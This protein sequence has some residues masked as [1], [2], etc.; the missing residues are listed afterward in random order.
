MAAADVAFFP[1][2]HHSPACAWALSQALA[3][4][5]PRQVLVEAPCDFLPLVV[6]LTDPETKPPIALLS[7]PADKAAPEDQFTAVYPFCAHSPEFVAL[8][9]ARGNDARIELIDLPARH[10]MMRR[11][12]PE[13]HGAPAPLIAEWR[14][15]HNAYVTELCARRGVRDALA[16]WDALFESQAGTADWRGF[17][18]AVGLYCG[19]MRA[20]TPAADMAA[21]GTQ[22]R[23]AHMAA[24]LARARA[25]PGPVA[26]I[27]GGFHTP[28][29]MEEAAWPAPDTASPPANA[30]LIRYGFQQ[31]DHHGGYGAG[32]P[33]PAFYQRLWQS[34]HH[35][36]AAPSDLAAD[37][38]TDFADWLRREKPSL[39]LPTPTLSAAVIA[40]GRL[41]ALRR[42]PAAGRSEIIDAVR[43][44][45]VKDAIE[46][47]TSPLLEALQ[48]F[49]VGEMIGGIPHGAAQPP[50][51][52]HVRARLKALRFNLEDGAPRH[53]DLDVL[54]RPA[55]AQAS[56]LL[57]TLELAG[58]EF[59]RRIA[60][61]DPYTGWRGDALFETWTYAW[62]PM[63]EARL[64]AR[65]ADGASLE[66]VA[67]ATLA[68]RHRALADSGRSRSA[69]ASVALLVTAARTGIEAAI[70]LAAGWCAD[71]IADDSQA[72]SIIGA[73]A[74][75]AGLTRPGPGA[76]EFAPRFQPLR[77]A[78]I[79]RL[80]LLFPDIA[81]TREDQ[82]PDLIRALAALGGLL[83]S[84]DDA[85][86]RAAFAP[87][88]QAALDRTAPPVLHGALL[89]FAGLLGTLPE[90]DVAAR[91]AALLAGTYVTAGD[92]AAVLTGCLAVAPRLIL[93]SP[94]ILEAADG[95]L[96]RADHEG[97]VAALPELRLAFS[98]LNPTEIDQIAAWAAARHGL[99]IAQI[100]TS[101]IPARE[102]TEN[103]GLSARLAG[104]WREDG[105]AA[106]LEVA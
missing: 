50:L 86:E 105:L 87:V 20:V 64:I 36:A 29:L 56:R 19:H 3:A 59:A 38:L 79:R 69:S 100:T 68:A 82:L 37:V 92:A 43:S 95:F 8:R 78:A 84:G 72:A 15:D 22:A 16:L 90:A 91:I 71:A 40:T 88:L 9:W 81:D 27:T 10:K 48:I 39:A 98:Q 58:A 13:R 104:V 75:T 35:R 42:L 6:H 55:H 51:V 53:R 28:A 103:L 7:L 102:M 2:R 93:R 41:A 76:P 74:V 24:R 23:E 52:A 66:D 44:C 25:E 49:L 32:L 80:L 17:F 57:F 99:D 101:G 94:A 83:A 65:A 73:I 4:L 70:D 26:V 85:L 45:G 89:A 60:G 18:K 97:F 5:R 106:W 54:R 12:M 34:L 11:R 67:L 21:D 33:H 63:V 46:L 14:L 77:S 62:S 96:A 47:G 31:L 1:I 30:Y 61:P